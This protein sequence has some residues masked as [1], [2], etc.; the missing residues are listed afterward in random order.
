MK[1]H[2]MFVKILLYRGGDEERPLID[3][4]LEKLIIYGEGV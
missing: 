1:T 3:S 4:R 2:I